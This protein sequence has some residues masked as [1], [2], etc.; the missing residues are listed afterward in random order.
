ML[1]P[2]GGVPTAF[3]ILCCKHFIALR[4]AFL[5]VYLLRAGGIR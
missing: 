4:A 1:C 2:A 5:G 3:I